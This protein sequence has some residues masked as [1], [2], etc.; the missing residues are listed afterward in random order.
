[1]K[2]TELI[3]DDKNFNKSKERGSKIID[4]SIKQFG[5]G[6]SILIDKNNRIIAGNKSTEAAIANG[7]NEVQ[8]IESDGRRIIAVKRVDIDIDSK[9][10][11][12]MALADNSSAY[13]N[14]NF[15]HALI[16]EEIGAFALE[17][18]GVVEESFNELEPNNEQLNESLVDNFFYLNVKIESER[19][20]RSL[21]E[22]LQ[23]RGYS[24]KIM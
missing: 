8:I 16:C 21:F 7:I 13:V 3:F 20:S 22:E 18:W 2:I 1:M 17:E 14:I 10:G 12:E 23:K 4:K 5:V 11:R 19:E 15:N 9:E 24:C 6:R